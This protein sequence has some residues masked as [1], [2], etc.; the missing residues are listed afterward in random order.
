LHFSE[1]KHALLLQVYAKGKQNTGRQCRITL[2]YVRDKQTSHMA[3]A[4]T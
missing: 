1:V 3:Y 4:Y 2:S